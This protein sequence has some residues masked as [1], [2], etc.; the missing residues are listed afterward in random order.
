VKRRTLPAATA[1]AAT[2][3]LLL[4]ACGG[5]GDSSKGNDKIAGA[6][7]GSPTSASLSASASSTPGRPKIALSADNTITFTP[8]HVGDPGQDA[9]LQDN[10]E[11]IRALNAAITAQNPRFPALQYYTEGEGAAAAQQW[12]QSFKN[13]GLTVTGTVRYFDRQVSVESKKTASLTYCGDESKG[14]TKVVKTNK[15]KKTKADK[16]SY[17]SYGVKVEKNATG[18]WE[19]VKIVSVRGAVKCQP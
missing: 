5:G 6:D 2:A 12:V 3:A 4:T 13:A 17:V 8:E 7:T 16:N 19:T 10:A 14:Y 15:V 9:I 11:F 18:V 1:L